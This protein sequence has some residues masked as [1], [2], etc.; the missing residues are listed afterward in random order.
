MARGT[1]HRKRRPRPTPSAVTSPAAPPRRAKAKPRHA[2]WEDELFFSRIKVHAKWMFV[3]LAV[4]FAAGFVFFGI[5]SGSS[6]ITSAMQNFFNFG[7][8]STSLSS[9]QNKANAHPKVASDWRALASKLEQD[10]KLDRA[11]TAL[12]HYTALAPKDESAL[13]E[14]AGLYVRRAGDYYNLYAQISGQSQLVSPSS[15][16]R[17]AQSSPFGKAFAN[18][19]PILANQASIISTQQSNDLTHLSTLN[20]QAEQTYKKLVKLVP[21][22]ATYQFQLAEVADSLGDKTVAVTAYKT[23][24]K[25]APN[26][27]LAPRAKTRLK[28]L[29]TPTVKLSPSSGKK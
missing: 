6:G 3:L 4:V 21:D 7:S 25:L 24:L 19:D 22:N 8:G 14:L 9:L 27:S 16:F 26:D 17:P 28:A 11:I 2:S 10:Q 12:E 15:I 20:A 1:Q 23:F 18:Q 13:E 5:G 29:Q